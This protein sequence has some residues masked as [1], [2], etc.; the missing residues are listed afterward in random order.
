VS[1]ERYPL[2]D[3]PPD[4]G[5]VGLVIGDVVG[6]NMVW[7]GASGQTGYLDDASGVMPGVPGEAAFTVGR[8]PT[9]CACWASGSWL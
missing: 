2:G 8:A 6:H 7:A 3:D 1:P 5:R 4:G 9:M